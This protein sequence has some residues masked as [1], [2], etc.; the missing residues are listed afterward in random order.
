MTMRRGAGVQDGLPAQIRKVSGLTV[1][2]AA[3]G[4]LALAPETQ[5]AEI[6]DVVDAFD[7]RFDHKKGETVEDPFDFHIE[8]RFK[9]T[10]KRAKITREAPCDPSGGDTGRF[11]RLLGSD[12]CSE[13]S[14]LVN[15][16]LRGTRTINQMDI[17]GQIGLYKDLEIHFELP[18]VF[19]DVRE[20]A[21]AGNGGDPT[22][23]EVDQ[24]NSSVDPSNSRI[25]EDIQRNGRDFTTFRLMDVAGGHE[26]PTRAGFG[27]MTLGIAWNPFNDFRD[28]TKATLKLGFDYK[29]PT[30]EVQKPGNEGVGR[31]VHELEWSIASS[32]RFKYAEPYFSVAY[33]L[34]IAAEASLFDNKGPGQTLESP[35]Q[36]AEIIFGSEFV[37]YEDLVKENKFA[38]DVGLKFGYT[39]EGRDYSLL[40]DGLGSSPCNGKTPA[41]I[42]AAVDAVNAGGLTGTELESAAQTAACKWIIEQPGNADA[43]SPEF[44]PT[45]ASAANT[46]F[47]H[48]GLTDYEAYATFGAYLGLYL[49]ATRFVQFRTKLELDHQQA[50]FLTAARTGKDSD[51]AN[52][53]VRF[54][55]EDER[56]PYYNPTLDAVGN[57]FRVEETTIFTWSL[58]MALQF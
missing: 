47:F 8:P 10:L 54:D 57:R 6:T 26:G 20:L 30:G 17:V 48:N 36:R 15:K 9:R 40:S 58:A 18:I 33:T 38:I 13:P 25:I 49:Q 56:N 34:P 31:G 1:A 24:T 12:R 37:P 29:I 3:V 35:G 32:K 41:E 22:S 53:T 45:D 21:F 5:A 11:A 16:E 27:D 19:S 28:D 55:D 23:D 14:V 44:T 52:D 42:F 50:H 43:G 39:A 46:Q 7:T 2:V 51:D 4:V